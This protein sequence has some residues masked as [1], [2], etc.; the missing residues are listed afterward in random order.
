MKGKAGGAN[1]KLCEWMEVHSSTIGRSVAIGACWCKSHLYWRLLW[2][3]VYKGG[4][5]VWPMCPPHTQQAAT[6]DA[7][8]GARQRPTSRAD[9]PNAPRTI[10]RGLR[11]PL[12]RRNRRP[13]RR[14][15]TPRAHTALAPCTLR[16]FTADYGS[17]QQI[18]AVYSRLRRFT[19][20][21][22]TDY[23]SAAGITAY[24]GELQQI[25]GD[26]V[27]CSCY[28]CYG[29]LRLLHVTTWIIANRGLLA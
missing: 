18:T 14:A 13:P 8:C 4:H 15:C 11:L 12:I 22:N 25:T 20:D 27:F 17:L 21:Y 7:A 9:A 26:A 23:R 24:Y 29:W 5:T 1:R 2:L 6:P 10:A 19:A 3:M 28:G 16:Q